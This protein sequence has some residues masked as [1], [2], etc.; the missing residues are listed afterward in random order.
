MSPRITSDDLDDWADHFGSEEAFAALLADLVMATARDLRR[1]RF[2]TGRAI[3]TSGW[4]GETNAGS[5]SLN[6]PDGRAGWEVSVRHD[7]L[8]K[9]NNDFANRCDDY[10]GDPVSAAVR[11]SP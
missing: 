3:Y 9:A 6:V 5:A 7:T 2:L 10:E 4:D 1:C 8:T 11:T